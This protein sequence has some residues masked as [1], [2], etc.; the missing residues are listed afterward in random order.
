MEIET[1]TPDW[2]RV[3]ENS[4]FFSFIIKLVLEV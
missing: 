1:K 2:I 3:L 4:T